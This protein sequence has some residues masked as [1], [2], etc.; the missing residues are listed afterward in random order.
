MTADELRRRIAA[1]GL[2]QREMANRLGLSLNGLFKQ[3]AGERKVS[4]Q[5]ELLLECV[6]RHQPRR[7]TV[8]VKTHKISLLDPLQP[9]HDA[10]RRRQA[11]EKTEAR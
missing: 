8:R 7:V 2:T 9:R 6:E 11:T 10:T 4:R 3:L 1:L 5:T